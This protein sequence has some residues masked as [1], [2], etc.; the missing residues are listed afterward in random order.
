MDD[1]GLTKETI[2][3]TRTPGVASHLTDVTHSFVGFEGQ[4]GVLYTRK[5]SSRWC[6]VC[7]TGSIASDKQ[8]ASLVRTLGGSC[9]VQGLVIKNCVYAGCYTLAAITCLARDLLTL[10]IVSTE[11]NESLTYDHVGTLAESM[12]QLKTLVIVLPTFINNQHLSLC[13]KLVQ[14]LP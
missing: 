7:I 8:L 5:V 2:N 13:D 14:P 12:P 6:L 4:A 9:C 11:P 1:I 3:H 10:Q